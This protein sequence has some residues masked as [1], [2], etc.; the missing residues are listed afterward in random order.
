ME[1]GFNK[2]Y[3]NSIDINTSRKFIKANKIFSK[4]TS[5][6]TKIEIQT[7]KNHDEMIINPDNHFYNMFYYFFLLCSNKLKYEIYIKELIDYQKLYF[8]INKSL[9]KCKKKY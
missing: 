1:W 3:Q 5:E 7:N 6:K 8:K 9:M 2:F 4:K